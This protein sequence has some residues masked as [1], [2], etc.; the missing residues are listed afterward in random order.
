MFNPDSVEVVVSTYNNPRA[1]DLVLLALQKQTL[2]GFRICIAD[3][4]SG[5]DTAALVTRWQEQ[6][7]DRL[8]HI[9]QIDRGFRKNRILN[10]AIAGSKADYLV[11]LDGD[12][13]PSPSFFARHLE[14]ARP[15]RFCTGG[16]IRLSQNASEDVTAINVNSGVVFAHPWLESHGALNNTRSRLKAGMYPPWLSSLAERL[17]TVGRT[18]NGGN[19]STARINL[20]RVN[21]FDENFGYGAEDIELG[22]RLNNAGIRGCHLRYTA[23]VLHLEHQRDYADLQ[24]K[25]QNK[26]VALRS[27]KA[28]KTVTARGIGEL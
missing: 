19:S 23:P 1:L 28:G 24:V 20:I 17:T 4:G 21:G 10:K 11:F 3:D 9:W 6:L 18:W 12:C 26:V 14:L 15:K 16:V 25:A 8:R 2:Q 22:Y 7:G 13:V 27:L 5:P